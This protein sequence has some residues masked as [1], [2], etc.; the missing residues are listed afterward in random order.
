MVLGG[1]RGNRRP[2]RGTTAPTPGLGA[3]RISPGTNSSG[4][5]SSGIRPSAPSNCNRS[6]TTTWVAAFKLGPNR[7]FHRSVALV[8]TPALVKLPSWGRAFLKCPVVPVLLWISKECIQY[9]TYPILSCR[10]SQV[11]ARSKRRSSLLKLF[12]LLASIVFLRAVVV[13]QDSN[14]KKEQKKPPTPGPMLAAGTVDFDTAE[15]ALTLVRSSDCPFAGW[16]LSPRRYH[17]ALAHGK[18]RRVEKLFDRRQT[19]TGGS[20]STGER[21]LNRR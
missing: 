8:S 2:V 5:S 6:T 12:F 14:D 9:A 13:A 16:L 19:P 18:F 10:G 3:R 7:G 4:F 11:I 17:A 21:H 1:W 15:F 20:A